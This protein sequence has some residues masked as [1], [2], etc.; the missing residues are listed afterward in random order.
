MDSKSNGRENIEED[1][2]LIIQSQNDFDIYI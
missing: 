2:E 1:S